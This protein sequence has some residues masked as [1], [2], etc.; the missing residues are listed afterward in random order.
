L[1]TFREQAESDHTNDESVDVDTRMD[2]LA[3]ASLEENGMTT[4]RPI[5]NTSS[6]RRQQS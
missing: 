2:E 1:E 4:T 3:R 5:T 6:A